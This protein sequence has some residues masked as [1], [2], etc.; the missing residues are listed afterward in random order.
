VEPTFTY[1]Y[2]GF[3]GQMRYETPGICAAV[4]WKLG[5]PGTPF[6]GENG[7]IQWS[8]PYMCD[9]GELLPEMPE[10]QLF[11]AGLLWTQ[12]NTPERIARTLATSITSGTYHDLAL[13]SENAAGC[14][15]KD[16]T[17]FLW[18]GCASNDHVFFRSADQFCW[19]TNPLDLIMSEDDVD[20]WAL[21]RC[22]HGD[23]AFIYHETKVQRVEQGHLVRITIDECGHMNVH[24]V[25]FDRFLPDPHL[26]SKTLTME[27]IVRRTREALLNAVRPLACGEPVGIMLSGGSGSAAILEAMKQVGVNGIAYHLEAPNPEASEY[28]FA[29]MACDALD[30]PLVRIPMSCG[31]DYLSFQWRFSHPDG[32]PWVRWFEQIAQQARKDGVTILVTGAGDDHAFGPEMEYSVHSLLSAR[33][34]WREKRKMLRGLL[35]TDWNVLDILRSAWPWPPRQLIGL[36][37]LAGP[38]KEDH[39]M[40]R[41]DFLTPLPPEFYRE[42]DA[43]LLHSPCFEPQ[44]MAVEHTILQPNGIRLYYPYYHR[45]VQAISLALPDA[46]RLMPAASLPPHVA[47]LVPELERIVDKPIL[48]LAC[49]DT[50]LPQEVVWRTW[51]VCTQASIQAFCLNHPQILQ[52]ILAEDSCLAQMKI[53]DSRRLE[54]VLASRADIRN[55]YTSLVASALVEIFLK[56]ALR[57]HCQRGGPVWK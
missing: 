20:S 55:N 56:K 45:E 39:H 49:E 34:P 28:R 36:T 32:H 9:N 3:Y 12:Q 25:V 21:R 1:H 35:S 18:V 24:D 57:D 46:Y 5:V 15:I 17:I 16:R 29:Q 47:A 11:I 2:T 14:L 44:C 19:S 48:R 8:H 30:V 50:L 23:D 54:Q 53:L 33:I 6:L 7:A 10:G 38:S 52:D 26:S 22:C 4:C 51:S 43:A 31:P 27:H 41:A 40:R 42:I 13:L 37:Y